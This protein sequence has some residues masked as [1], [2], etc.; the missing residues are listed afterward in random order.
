MIQDEKGFLGRLKQG[1]RKTAELMAVAFGNRLLRAAFLLCRNAPEAQDLVQ[2]TLCQAL[3]SIKKFKGDSSLYTWLY[4][5][6]RN[7]Y[8][9]HCRKKKRLFSLKSYSMHAS[10]TP[11]PGYALDL[12]KTY[13]RVLDALSKLPIKHR[14]ILVLR[15]VEDLKILEIAK[16]LSIPPGT[17]KSRLHHAKRRIK[18]KISPEWNPFLYPVKERNP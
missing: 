8:L 15:Y 5:I 3:E 11:N 6:L 18:K 7:L 10:T 12:E 9:L 2:E 16:V 1:D 13:S 17:V 4:S 14:E